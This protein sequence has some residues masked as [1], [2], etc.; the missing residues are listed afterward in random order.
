MSERED[1]GHKTP[2]DAGW[3]RELL[4][5]LAW[6]SLKEQRR[7]RRWGLLTRFLFL[8][9]LVALLWVFTADQTEVTLH[10]PGD[11][12]AAVVDLQGI[13]AEDSEASAEL[14][15]A[16]LR[17][18]FE[19]K[20]A[21]GVI[22]RANSPGG[23]PVQSDYVFNE[24]RRLREEYPDMPLYAV[25]TDLCASGCYYI[26]AAADEIYA[27]P[28]SI[29]GSIGVINAGFGFDEAIRKLGLER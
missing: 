5:D 24:I 14:V 21:K 26:A 2:A 29:V 27:N 6:A 9:Y 4:K 28:S 23:S 18:A 25:I 19:A 17:D 10:K 7:A 1:P 12:F 3:E 22:L 16:A 11:Q 15:I 20:G 13:I 8:G